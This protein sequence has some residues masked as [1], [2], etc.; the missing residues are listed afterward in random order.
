MLS[1]WYYVAVFVVYAYL[2]MKCNRFCFF[3]TT[4]SL[5]LSFSLFTS[6][7]V[8]GKRHKSPNTHFNHHFILFYNVNRH[9]VELISICSLNVYWIKLW[10]THTHISRFYSKTCESFDFTVR[11]MNKNEMHLFIH[12]MKV[13]YLSIQTNLKEKKQ[14]KIKLDTN[15]LT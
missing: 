5:T 3:C 2:L 8:Y 13:F 10:K 6:K 12:I 14:K 15:T 9:N 11:K 4:F 1:D 7:T